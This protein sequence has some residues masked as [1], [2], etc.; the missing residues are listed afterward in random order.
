MFFTKADDPAKIESFSNSLGKKRPCFAE[1]FIGCPVGIFVF[2]Y[3]EFDV[4]GFGFL[5]PSSQ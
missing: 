4:V 2:F 1:I 5:V 3:L